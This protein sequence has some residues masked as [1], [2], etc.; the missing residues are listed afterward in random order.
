MFDFKIRALFLFESVNLFQSYRNRFTSE[1]EVS[2]QI[3]IKFLINAND[4][5]QDLSFPSPLFSGTYTE[6]NGSATG[7]MTTTYTCYVKNTNNKLS[8]YCSPYIMQRNYLYPLG[9]TG[10]ANESGKIYNYIAL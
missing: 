4:S 8:W 3:G 7:S 10:Q 5:Y 2:S 6:E 9:A 1:L